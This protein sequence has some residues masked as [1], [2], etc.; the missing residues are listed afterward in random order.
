MSE[1]SVPAVDSGSQ[2]GEPGIG[3]ADFGRFQG[4]S[5]RD[6]LEIDTEHCIRCG[7]CV[8]ACPVFDELGWES[9]TPRGHANVINAYLDGTLEDSAIVGENFDL[10][11]KCKQ[12]LE[13]CPTGIEIPNLVLRGM[14]HHHE[15][16]GGSLSDLV[17][18]KPRLLNQVGGFFAPLSNVVANTAPVRKLMEETIGMDSRRPLPHFST[19]SFTDWFASHDPEPALGDLDRDVAL[20]VDCYVDRNYPEIGKAAVRVLERMGASVSL[21]DTGCCGRA[22]LS[23]GRIDEAEAKAD[24]HIEDLVSIAESGTDVVAI[25][26]SCAAMMTTEYPEMYDSARVD[27]FAERTHEL[28][29][30]LDRH[31]DSIGGEFE[32]DP[33]EDHVAYH[34]HCHM[35]EQDLGPAAANVLQRIPGLDVDEPIVS[36]CGMA[37]SFGYQT[38][39][40]D[41]S[42]EIGENLFE[43]IRES[44]GDPMAI[45]YSC[46]L[47]I[48]DGMDTEVDHP[49]HVVERSTRP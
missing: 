21:A 2:G 15:E 17:Y 29:V 42:L 13:P 26:P 33:V 44:G 11:L 34:S 22:A 39:Y 28:M 19:S 41:T 35:K 27:R 23:K 25:E 16:N 24:A 45:G 4:H 32:F 3:G 49:I 48:S 46:R 6:D 43:Q 8:T 12:C 31:L 37:G 9:V 14:E 7:L 5:D 18:A 40:Y 10:C 47:Q 36:C 20:Y 38:E 30:Y 1:P